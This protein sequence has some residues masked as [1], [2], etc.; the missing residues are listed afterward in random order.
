MHYLRV[1]HAS[2]RMVRNCSIDY[3][4]PQVWGKTTG[5]CHSIKRRDTDDCSYL[6]RRTIPHGGSPAQRPGHTVF[7]AIQASRMRQAQRE[8]ARYRHLMPEEFE[9]AAA[10]LDAR[11]ERSL[12][13]VR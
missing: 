1:P 5:R 2:L 10:R 13:F 7:A 9:R 4:S 11:S 6:R 3:D 8:V 12:P